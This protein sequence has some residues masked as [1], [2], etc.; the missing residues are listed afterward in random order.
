MSQSQI[1]HSL[2]FE[3]VGLFPRER[4]ALAFIINFKATRKQF[5]SFE[6]IAEGLD[7][8]SRSGAQYFVNKLLLKGWFLKQPKATRKSF[9][10]SKKLTDLIDAYF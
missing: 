1:N 5:P 8:K 6:D 4:E 7:L 10:Y 9:R 3:T 2:P